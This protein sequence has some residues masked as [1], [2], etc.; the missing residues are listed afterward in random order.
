MSYADVN[1]LSLYYSEHGSGEP[2]VLLHGGIGSGDMFAAI[3]PELAAGRRVITVDLQG[4]GRTADIDRPFRPESMADDVAA[5]VEHLGLAQTDVMGYSL[6]GAVALRIAIQHPALVR[7]LVLLSVPCRRDA[8]HPEVVT[9]M[10]EMRPE[11]AEVMKQ[12]PPYEL[13]SRIAPRPEDWPVLIAKTS[14]ALKVDY[15]WTAETAALT[16]PTMLVFADADS[17]RPAHIVEFFGLL[18]GGLRDA[19]WDNSH[20]P[21]ARLAILPGTT[22]YDVFMSPML[23]MAVIPF[24]DEARGP[25]RQSRADSPPGP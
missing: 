7:R 17:V 5:L 19:G 13:Y 4:H 18:G 24:L 8:N 2:L 3:L 1:G 9:A 14:D 20:R 23:G 15:D 22:H 10:E 21:V 11:V 16:A 6:G 25:G 12:S